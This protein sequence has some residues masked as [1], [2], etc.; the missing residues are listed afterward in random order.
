MYKLG[1]KEAEEPEITG[2]HLLDYGESMG[3][4]EKHLLV[5]YTIAF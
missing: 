5:N 1:L 3:I 4:P 2:Q